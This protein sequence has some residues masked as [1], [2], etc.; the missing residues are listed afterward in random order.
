MRSKLFHSEQHPQLRLVHNASTNLAQGGN[1]IFIPPS[2]PGSYSAS[3]Q[4][5]QGNS[6]TGTEIPK[7]A[8]TKLP[9]LT[10]HR[11]KGEVTQF[12]TFWDTFESAVHSNP[13]LTKIDKFS[14]LVSLL[15]GSASRAIEGL[16]VTEENY[17][18][19]VEILKKRSGKQQQLISAHMEEL[20]NQSV[21]LISQVNFVFCTTK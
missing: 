17:D 16:P 21:L 4:Q 6:G 8:R 14:Y 15:E 13:G 12:R 9:K 10:L 5:P 2:S 7:A 20:L 1:T 11:F 19:A 3:P 18:S